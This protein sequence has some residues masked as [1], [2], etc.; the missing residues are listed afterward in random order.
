MTGPLPWTAVGAL[1]DRAPRYSDLW[2]HRVH[3]LAAHRWHHQGRSFPAALKAEWGQAAL[4]SLVV[5]P[6]LGRVAEATSAPYLLMKGPE[7]ATRYP[8][9]ILRPYKDLDLLFED[10]PAAQTALLAA[11][12]VPVGQPELYED[13]HHL[14]PLH[15]PGSPL[16]IE[17]H[18]RPKWVAGLPA[19]AVEEL[20]AA[21]VPSTTGIEGVLAP[22]PHHH[23]LLVAA[24]AWAHVPLG[25]LLHAIDVAV[26]VAETEEEEVAEQ[27]AR[28]GLRR[29]WA[30]TLAGVRWTF[31]GLEP[32]A[33]LRWW[34]GGLPAVRERT[35]LESHLRRA[36]AAYWALPPRAATATAAAALANAALPQHG[37]PVLRKLRRTSRAARNAFVRLSEHHVAIEG[38]GAPASPALTSTSTRR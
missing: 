10:A 3:L 35:V 13:I 37:E 29:T 30:S 20:L 15:L 28:W 22:A 23:A 12:F 8:T 11:G 9:P 6:L 24:H 26:L 36:G 38:D 5:E 34:A 16:V 25:C 14:R 17:V 1:I 31:E 33:M 18:S 4:R 7:L 32:S 2:A 27:A 21:A 19:P